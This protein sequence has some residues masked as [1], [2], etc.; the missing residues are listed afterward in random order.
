MQ[1]VG[2]EIPHETPALPAPESPPYQQESNERQLDHLFHYYK[3][4]IISQAKDSLLTAWNFPLNPFQFI[5]QTVTTAAAQTQYIADQTILHQEATSQIATGVATNPDRFGLKVQAVS[6]ATT[7]KFAI[8]QYP[9]TTTTYPYWSYKLS[10]LVKLRFNSTHS[11]TVRFKMLLMYRLDAPPAISASEPISG[12]AGDNLALAAGWTAIKPLNDPI[13]T[14]STSAAGADV[15]FA[16]NS[17]QMPASL[18]DTMYLS[19]VFYTL[20]NMN[21]TAASEDYFVIDKISLSN[22]DFA[23]D[24]QPQTF[25]DVTRQCQFYYE[26]SY[27]YLVLPGTSTT[28]GDL[29][30]LMTTNPA[31]TKGYANAFSVEY[32]T[33]KRAAATVILYSTIGSANKVSAQAWTAGVGS[34][35]VDATVASFWAASGSGTKSVEYLPNTNTALTTSIANDDTS[36]VIRFQYSANSLLG[37]PSGIP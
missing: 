4:S 31:T 9:D 16:F 27:D 24:T 26:K 10:A 8:F 32:N 35:F 37:A 1:I 7:T 6:G 34:A 11:T 17:F 20:D 21:S 14:D 5:T 12:W 28:N 30:K 33:V 13:Y 15:S 36:C 2:Q 25:D 22:N 3:D 19:A 29:I 23:I 18:S